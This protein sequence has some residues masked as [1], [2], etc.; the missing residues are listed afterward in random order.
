MGFGGVT[1]G[2]VIEVT[3]IGTRFAEADCSSWEP[4]YTFSFP[5]AR[6][7]SCATP[8]TASVRFRRAGATTV[9]TRLPAAQTTMTPAS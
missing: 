5:P 3:G 4:E 8:P 9:F 7:K 1:A 6:A 2:D